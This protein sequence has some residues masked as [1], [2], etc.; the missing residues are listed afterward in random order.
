MLYEILDCR[1]E[2]RKP[3]D[4]LKKSLGT[5]ERKYENQTEFI[6]SLECNSHMGLE[7]DKLANALIP[8]DPPSSTDKIYKGVK[9][10][11]NGDCLYNALSLALVGDKSYAI[12][13][14]LLVALELAIN[15]SFYVQHP[16]FSY[17]PSGSHHPKTVFSLCLM[18]SGNKVFHDSHQNRELAILSEG[19]TA[20]KPK[21]WSGYF[22]VSA[23]STVLAR[24][25]FSS[26][27]NC[28]SRTRDF[29]HGIVYPR[30]VTFS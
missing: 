12:L 3:E 18:R 6:R 19:H 27:P 5:L 10:T 28:H 23:L 29:V 16:K 22:H 8:E 21:E 11:R 20:S 14:R 30:M 9:T 13:L 26:Y 25:V 2:Q 15:A 24:P 1:I 17:F 7:E 4:E